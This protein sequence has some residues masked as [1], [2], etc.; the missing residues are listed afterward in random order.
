MIHLKLKIKENLF[1]QHKVK[2]AEYSIALYDLYCDE[3]WVYCKSKDHTS[4]Q[5]DQQINEVVKDFVQNNQRK[6][7]LCL[8]EMTIYLLSKL[9]KYDPVLLKAYFEPY[10]IQYAE[11]DSF[12]SKY[13]AQFLAIVEEMI[14]E[15]SKIPIGSYIVMK[16]KNF[17][18]EMMSDYAS[19]PYTHPNITD[20]HYIVRVIDNL[21]K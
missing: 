21:C 7:E 5:L 17:F 8:M 2:P 16:Y 11:N 20:A 15:E 3:Y 18:D 13:L 6:F 9:S 4:N 1:K 10:F 14:V 12:Q 19:I